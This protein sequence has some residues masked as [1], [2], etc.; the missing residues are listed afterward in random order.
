MG[1]CLRAAFVEEFQHSERYAWELINVHD[2]VAQGIEIFNRTTRPLQKYLDH[3]SFNTIGNVL[4]V[5][6]GCKVPEKGG[7]DTFI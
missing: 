7:A 6:A 5:K 3:V 1:D 4:R 2:G